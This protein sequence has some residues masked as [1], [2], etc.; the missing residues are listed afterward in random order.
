MH[1]NH[2]VRVQKTSR[3]VLNNLFW[4]SDHI[5]RWSDFLWKIEGF[6]RH[7]NGWKYPEVSRTVV[8]HLAAFPL[9]AGLSLVLEF[10]PCGIETFTW[11]GNKQL[12]HYGVSKFFLLFPLQRQL[13]QFP[14]SLKVENGHDNKRVLPFYI[15]SYSLPVLWPHTAATSFPP[16]HDSA[17]AGGDPEAFPHQMRYLDP[18]ACFLIFPVFCLLPV[19]PNNRHRE[20]PWADVSTSS[21]LSSQQK[22]ILISALFIYFIDLRPRRLFKTKL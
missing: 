11:S 13:V 4:S 22:K 10:S 15:C 8:G 16:A 1:K 18:A 17:L 12:S 14:F 19:G 21:T 2:L 20:A 5:L 9:N 6:G 3:C 7:K